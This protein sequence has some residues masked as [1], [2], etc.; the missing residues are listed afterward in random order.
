M[1]E[2]TVK[3]PSAKPLRR[4]VCKMTG[5]TATNAVTKIRYKKIKGKWVP[6]AR[7]GIAINRKDQEVDGIECGSIADLQDDFPDSDFDPIDV[8]IQQMEDA[9]IFLEDEMD[10]Y[11]DEDG[12]FY[13]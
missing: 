11:E 7:N 13:Y 3:H 2:G 5:L 1:E 9:G 4:T 8:H 12:N 6:V 10:F